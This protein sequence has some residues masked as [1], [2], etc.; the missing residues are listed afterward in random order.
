MEKDIALNDE[1][2]NIVKILREDLTKEKKKTTTMEVQLVDRQNEIED[3]TRQLTMVKKREDMHKQNSQ[4][5]QYE[6]DKLRE[7]ANSSMMTGNSISQTQV[8]ELELQI[9]SLKS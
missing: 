9:V 5:L 8:A 6:L 7:T 4:E 3:L 1:L 2:Q